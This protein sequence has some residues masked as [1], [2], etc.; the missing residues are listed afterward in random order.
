MDIDPEVQNV[1]DEI[2]ELGFVTVRDG[3]VVATPPKYNLCHFRWD[4]WTP[5][6]KYLTDYAQQHDDFG[7]EFFV[8]LYDGWREYSS[9]SD[10]TP[11]FVPWSEV[12]DHFLYLSKGVAGEPRFR[13]AHTAPKDVYPELPRKVITYNAHKDDRNAVVIPDAEFLESQYKPF[14]SQVETGD[15]PWDKKVPVALWRGSKNITPGHEYAYLGTCGLHPREYITHNAIALGLD[16]SWVH[17]PIHTQL[18]HK[19]LLDMDGMVNAWSGLYWK[20]KSKSVVLKHKS[21]WHQWYYPQ[22]KAWEHYV[23][24]DTMSDLPSVVEWCKNNDAQCKQ[25]AENATNFVSKFT[26]DYAV[27]DFRILT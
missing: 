8:C 19:Y 27:Y 10:G 24:F 9:P 11:I 7:G 5:T 26:Y 20:L 2:V 18:R 15:V 16:A 14:T 21:H 13:H 25:I 6:I 17:T 3:R 23:P 4:R 1:L 22:L 12:T